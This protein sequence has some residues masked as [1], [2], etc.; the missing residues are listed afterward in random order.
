MFACDSKLKLLFKT[1]SKILNLYI[2]LILK[3]QRLF[4]RFLY[5]NFLLFSYYANLYEICYHTL[6]HF[7]KGGPIKLTIFENFKLL[8]QQR[9]LILENFR[10]FGHYFWL[11]SYKRYLRGGLNEQNNKY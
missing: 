3:I 5:C 4:E 6:V 8:V 9:V 11:W 1:T 7:F 2:F 10:Q